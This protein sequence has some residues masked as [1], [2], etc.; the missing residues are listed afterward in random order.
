MYYGVNI[1]LMVSK[2]GKFVMKQIRKEDILVSSNIAL[3][4]LWS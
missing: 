1:R 3:A 2:E 4:G